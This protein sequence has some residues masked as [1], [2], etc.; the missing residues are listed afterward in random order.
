MS[1]TTIYKPIG[2]AKTIKK[3]VKDPKEQEEEMF[4]EEDCAEQ[5]G[6]LIYSGALFNEKSH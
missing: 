1:A 3:D 5:E 2:W 4:C 6:K